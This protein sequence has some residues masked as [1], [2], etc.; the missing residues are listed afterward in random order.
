MGWR[1]LRQGW[2]MLFI[3]PKPIKGSAKRTRWN[4]EFGEAKKFR[5]SCGCRVQA[6][7]W[8]GPGVNAKERGFRGKSKQGFQNKI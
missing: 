8:F 7:G 1:L 2:F 4:P 3:K 6:E 5:I